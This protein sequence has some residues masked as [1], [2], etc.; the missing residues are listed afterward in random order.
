MSPELKRAF[1]ALNRLSCA[2]QDLAKA[3]EP[4]STPQVLGLPT[5][6]LG[7]ACVLLKKLV[8][9]GTAV[10]TAVVIGEAVKL[11]LNLKTL[12]R[13]RLQLGLVTKKSGASWYWLWPVPIE[14]E[15]A[16][17]AGEAP[18]LRRVVDL[19]EVEKVLL[20]PE[21]EEAIVADLDVEP[22]LY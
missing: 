20:T 12:Q 10:A 17:R 14:Q 15:A 16:I 18:K 9:P 3:Q 6:E 19:A 5:T 4:F 22:E 13:A 8:L 2:L 21:D 1:T 7:R 11:H